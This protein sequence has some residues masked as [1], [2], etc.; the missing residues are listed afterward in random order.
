[1]TVWRDAEGLHWTIQYKDGKPGQPVTISQS[2]GPR[3]STKGLG[4]KFETA[5]KCI[6]EE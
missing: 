3:K 6:L 2:I 4:S 5:L 1:M